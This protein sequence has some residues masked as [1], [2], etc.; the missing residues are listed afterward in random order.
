MWEIILLACCAA[1]AYRSIVQT[2]KIRYPPGPR[3][4]PLVGNA[5]QLKTSEPWHTYAKWEEIYGM[6]PNFER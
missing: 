2:S 6:I 3:G 1:L 4:L 5:F